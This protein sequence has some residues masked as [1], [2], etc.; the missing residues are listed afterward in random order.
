MANEVVVPSEKKH[1]N[2]IALAAEKFG[3]LHR[4]AAKRA[5]MLDV[6]H[7]KAR[8]RPEEVRQLPP[9]A[10]L[11]AQQA[12]LAAAVAPQQL[13]EA[14]AR[15][16]VAALAAGMGVPVG[17]DRIDFIIELLKLADAENTDGDA[18]GFSPQVVFT[19]IMRVGAKAEF[20]L[21]PAD[22]VKAALEARA[23][24]Q[25]ALSA[26]AQAILLVKVAQADNRPEWSLDD[27]D[28]DGEDDTPPV[29]SDLDDAIQF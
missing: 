19:A 29:S 23:T 13:N 8:L 11:E 7:Q 26:T 18:E 25:T 28:G 20:G 22:V 21:K 10:E 16:L 9:I 4:I 17:P 6:L 2:K 5:A 15:W 1:R 14:A 24:Y 12:A 27:D 3:G